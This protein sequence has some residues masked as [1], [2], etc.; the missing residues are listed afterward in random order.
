MTAEEIK[1]LILTDIE[2]KKVYVSKWDSTCPNCGEEVLEGDEMVYIGGK[3]L[4]N[5]CVGEIISHLEDT[6]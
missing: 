2:E 3:R 6:L 1:Q 4:C 5:E